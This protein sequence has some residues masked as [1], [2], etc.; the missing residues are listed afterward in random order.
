MKL[1]K[2]ITAS[3][4]LAFASGSA[5]WS[6]Q[7][8]QTPR[9]Q[10]SPYATVMQRI[11]AD[12]DITVTYN[13]PAVKGREIWGKLVPYGLAPGN[14]YSDDKPYPWRGGANATTTIQFSKPVK[15]KGNELP[16]G[17]YGLHFIPSE[18]DWIIIFSKNSAGPGSFRYKE[19]EDALRVTVTPVKA[20]FT[21]WLE[22]GFENLSATG[23]TGYLKWEELKIS[24][25][26]TL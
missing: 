7:T 6:Q 21:E 22:Y 15:I 4:A 11:G 17:K 2:L 23:A 13:R 20:P 8:A 3:L 10:T 9:P 18:K 12:T 14:Q 26:I 5:L 1:S 24:Y 19:E 25:E 16:A